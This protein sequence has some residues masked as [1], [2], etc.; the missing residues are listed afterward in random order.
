MHFEGND[1]GHA[2]V[3]QLAPDLPIYLP[4]DAPGDQAIGAFVKVNSGW[5]YPMPAA[6]MFVERPAMFVP[7]DSIRWAL[8]AYK[9]P[10]HSTFRT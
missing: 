8:Q 10:S 5:L 9:G 6:F 3:I 2:A 1:I 4:D 7:H